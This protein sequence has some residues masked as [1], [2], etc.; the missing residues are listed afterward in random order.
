M[1]PPHD[2]YFHLI[3]SVAEINGCKIELVHNQQN[4]IF[5]TCSACNALNQKKI[6]YFLYGLKVERENLMNSLSESYVHIDYE[7]RFLRTAYMLLYFPFYIEPIYYVMYPHIKELVPLNDS[8]IKVCFIGGGPSPELLGVGKAVST[9]DYIKKINCSV[10]DLVKHWGTERKY[11]TQRMLKEDYFPNGECIIKHQDFDLWSKISNLP[12][13]IKEANIII[14]Q[15]C[16][17]DC[18]QGRESTVFDNFL[19]IWDNM[20]VNSSL[21]LLD[22]NYPNIFSLLSN[23]KEFILKKKGHVLQDLMKREIIRNNSNAADF[24]FKKCNHI[25]EL[26][27]K[28]KPHVKFY[29]LILRKIS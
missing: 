2:P 1:F 22:L 20:K 10:L 12:N 29:S 24:S 15:N 16:L 14:S 4:N 25:E 3:K 28:S 23:I 21:I 18:P 27:G 26:L 6:E 19:L 17:N 8:E 11:C 7:K 9:I 5:P 13:F